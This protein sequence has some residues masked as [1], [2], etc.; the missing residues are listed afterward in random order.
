MW[1]EK[2]MMTFLFEESPVVV[3]MSFSIEIPRVYNK[4]K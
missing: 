4:M 3:E 1:T 2:M